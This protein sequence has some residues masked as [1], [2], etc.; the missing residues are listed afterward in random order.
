MLN[1]TKLSTGGY[2]SGCHSMLVVTPE[3]SKE[4]G[5]PNLRD[6]MGVK[7]SCLTNLINML[8]YTDRK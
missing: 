1:K 7:K 8:T 5:A 6:I 4:T 2:V 3:T